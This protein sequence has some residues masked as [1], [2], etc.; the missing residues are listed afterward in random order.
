MNLEEELRNPG[1]S[2]HRREMAELDLRLAKTERERLLRPPP[3]P[4]TED[5]WHA[6][7]RVDFFR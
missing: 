5:T 1:L 4:A 3:A 7:E 6:G 2:P